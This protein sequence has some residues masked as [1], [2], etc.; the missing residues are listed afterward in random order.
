MASDPSPSV[1]DLSSFS[2]PLFG[3]APLPL[4]ASIE[5]PEDK[6]KS[7]SHI[8]D[9]DVSGPNEVENPLFEKCRPRPQES[10]DTNPE[11]DVDISIEHKGKPKVSN[12]IYDECQTGLP[13][14]FST[15]TK[16]ACK[17]LSR[18]LQQY[19]TTYM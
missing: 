19:A 3:Q 11:K 9:D 14:N 2:N 13:K 1:E 8:I 18:R 12:Q 15:V 7:I 16:R 4:E 5:T 10:E 17:R 6:I